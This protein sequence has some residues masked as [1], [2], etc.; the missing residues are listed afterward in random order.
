MAVATILDNASL[1]EKN[2]EYWK[3]CFPKIPLWQ[4]ERMCQI[5]GK[6][7]LEV[8]NHNLAAGSGEGREQWVGQPVV[9][10]FN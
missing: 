3:D 1:E 6:T 7:T 8:M 9:K 2:S 4:L 10:N 5:M